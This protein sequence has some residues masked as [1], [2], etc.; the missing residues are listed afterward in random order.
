MRNR[1]RALLVL[2]TCAALALGGCSGDGDVPATVTITGVVDDGGPNSPIPD[3]NCRFSNDDGDDAGPVATGQD[4]RFTLDVPRNATGQMECSPPN[5]SQLVL[6][7]RVATGE[8]EQDIGLVNPESSLIAAIVD[9]ELEQGVLAAEDV[10]DRVAELEADARLETVVRALNLAVDAIVGAALDVELGVLYNDLSDNGQLDDPLFAGIADG[11][12]AAIE[13]EIGSSALVVAT[14]DFGEPRTEDFCSQVAEAAF[15]AC[16][17]EV[18]DDLWIA[19]AQCIN[20]ADPDERAA[21]EED[22]EGDR[23]EALEECEDQRDARVKVCGLVGEARYDPAFDPANFVDPDEIGASVTPNPYFPLIAGTQWV[24]EKEDEVITDTVTDRTKLIEG[25]TCRVV[26]DVVE[27]D[28]EIIEITEDWYAQDLAGNVWYCGE[29]AQEFETFEGDDPERPELVDIDGSFKAGRE[30][31]KPG[32][33]MPASPQEGQAFRQEVALGEAEDLAEVTS[34]TGTETV[35]AAACDGD[36]LVTRDFTPLEPG[37]NEIKYYAPGVGLILEVDDEGNRTELVEILTDVDVDAV[38]AALPDYRRFLTENDEEENEMAAVSLARALARTEISQVLA[39]EGE[40]CSQT[41]EAVFEACGSEALDDF[42]LARANCIN[43]SDPLE[44]TECEDE[45]AAEFADVEEECDAQLE[46]RL[47][48]PANFVDPDEIGVTVAPNPHFP[49]VPGMQWVWQASFEEDGETVTETITDIVTDE[50]KLVHGVPCRVLRDFVEEDG[51]LIELTD[52]WYAQDLDGNVWYCGEIA[53]DFETVAGD[54]PELPELVE[55]DGSFKA[56]RDGDKPGILMPVVAQLQVGLAYRQEVSLGNAEDAAQV[57]SLTGDESVPAADCEGQCL[58]TREFTPIEP[59]VEAFKH[60]APGIG[61]ILEVEGAVRV[62]LIE[63]TNPSME[64]A[65]LLIE[66]NATDEDTGFQGFADGDPWNEISITGPD[67]EGILTVT[68]AGGLFDFGLTELFFETSEPPN[69]EVSIDDVLQRLDEGTYTAAGD[70][71]DGGVSTATATFSHDIP[72]GPALMSPAD[73]ATGLDPS[74]VTVVWEAVTTDLDGDPEIDIVGYQV[75][76]E[77]DA[78]PEFPQ[79]FARPVFS[80]HVPADVTSVTVSAEFM[81]DDACYKYEVLAIEE[82][83]N[84]TLATA[85]FE[86]GSGCESDEPEEDDTPKL[87]AA[88]LLI[89]HNAT[90][91]DTGFQGFA[92]GD[93]WNQ[94]SITG[95]D[96]ERILNVTPEG[97]LFDFGLT[98]LFF[99]TSEPENDEVPIDEV[100]ERLPEGTYSFTGDMVDGGQSTVDATFSHTIPA[101]PVLTNPADGATD[102]DPNNLVVAWEGVTTDLDGDPDIT[103]VGY[104]VIVEL[105]EESEFPQGFARPVFSVY[106][107]ATATSVTVPSEFMTSGA[108]YK[109]EVLAIEESG[110]QTLSSA[111]F[112]TQ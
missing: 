69:D 10:S 53:Q 2:L 12:N 89:E 38:F 20:L 96:G 62:E 63:F 48:L 57:V 95:P 86:T 28:G 99:E 81:E 7:A 33:L 51:E 19:L 78:P 82:S 98:E 65:K 34:L 21:C 109:Y 1:R 79:G 24:W 35:P 76:V 3:A 18:R 110:N 52:D 103:I 102:M 80:V 68:P 67:G 45:A 14:A 88:K 22:A 44:R 31:A 71:V 16:G 87:V 32:I 93:P 49:L 59:G 85:A 70:M 17:N 72:A 6:A 29:I 39:A 112:T 46:A 64:E 43:I 37:V 108:P 41:A 91:E 90:D 5:Q 50:I 55:I 25:V 61:L 83:G 58:V 15:F 23:E 40:Y 94:L 92:D 73:G 77:E 47:A 54:D 100:L 27:A 4:G 105:D 56:G 66:H 84:Q 13:A 11:V 60:Y 9:E 26:L 111:G 8:T 106:L 30:G 75:I 101:G 36:C 104:Q 97:G 107:P 74:N 42:W